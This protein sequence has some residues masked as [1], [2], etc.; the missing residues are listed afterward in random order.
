LHHPPSHI[1]F[2]WKYFFYTYY[3]NS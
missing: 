1:K 2:P 3:Y